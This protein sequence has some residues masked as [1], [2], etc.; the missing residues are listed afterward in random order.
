M[1][2]FLFS[3]SKPNNSS[4]PISKPPVQQVENKPIE[5]SVKVDSPVVEKPVEEVDDKVVITASHLYS[6]GITTK[7]VATFL[8]L[9]N[10]TIIQY[11]IN[12]PI[13]VCHWLSQC[14]HESENFKYLEELASGEQYENNKELGNTEPG[15]GPKFRGKGV[16]QITGRFNYKKYGEFIEQDLLSGDNPKKL[17]Q[18]NLATYS[19]GWFWTILKKDKHG[20]N[21]NY[22]ADNNDF[23]R[24]TYTI[25][26]GSTGLKMRFDKFRMCLSVFCN[27][28]KETRISEI[29]NRF[30]E[31]I[32]KSDRTPMEKVMFA[33]IPNVD[34][35]NKFLS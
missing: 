34:A 33:A 17:S 5:T 12:T 13:R 3:S 16:L 23:I 2:K 22:Y 8:P 9:L 14:M 1:F 29:K 4:K 21:L 20:N 10:E 30:L 35:L 7:N 19:S 28:E 11:K 15:D 6:L 31:I 24:I 27:N 32:N 25:N 26:G 18:P